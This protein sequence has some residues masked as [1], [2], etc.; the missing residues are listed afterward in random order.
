[1]TTLCRAILTT[2]QTQV[3]FLDTPG[4][5]T[6]EEAVKFKLETSLVAGETEGMMV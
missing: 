3:V 1:M 4:M 6:A 2:G 5:V